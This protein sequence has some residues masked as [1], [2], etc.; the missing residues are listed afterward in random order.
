MCVH[1]FCVVFE[2]SNLVKKKMK[3]GHFKTL[4]Q[5]TLGDLFRFI[6]PVKRKKG[7]IHIGV[8]RVCM[9]GESNGFLGLVQSE[10]IVSE[11]LVGGG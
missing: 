2:K 9:R 4:R 8:A 11:Y 10:G 6:Q 3:I 7:T 1:L 5:G